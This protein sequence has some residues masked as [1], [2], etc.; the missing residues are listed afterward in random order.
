MQGHGDVTIENVA[1]TAYTGVPIEPTPTV[2]VGERTLV[3]G[4]DYAV[5][6]ANNTGAG[7]ATATIAGMN[8]WTGSASATFQIAPRAITPEVTLSQTSYTYDGKVKTPEVTVRDDSNVLTEGTDYDVT[9]PAG[10][11]NVGTYAVEVTL[12]GNYSGAGSASFGIAKAANPLV[13]NATAKG[14]KG[15]KVK[16]SKLRKNAQTIACK[17]VISVANAQGAVTYNIVKVKAKKKLAKQATKRIK[18]AT[19]SN[20]KLKKGLK[21]GTYKVTIRITAIG[22]DSFYP[23]AKDVVVKVK[24]T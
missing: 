24:V 4:A 6:Y 5:S 12:K 17:K 7:T 20:L 13:A 10:R 21:K 23:T 18:L 19:G 9:Y 11:T 8:Q 22:N 3:A 14:K 2:R 1:D 15:I 16:A